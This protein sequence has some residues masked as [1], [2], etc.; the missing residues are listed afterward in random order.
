MMEK[1]HRLYRR[2]IWFDAEEDDMINEMCEEDMRDWKNEIRWII[3]Q[4]YKRRKWNRCEPRK[5]E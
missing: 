1:E 3:R 4:E 2:T 5:D